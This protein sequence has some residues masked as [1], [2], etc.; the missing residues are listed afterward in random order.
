M[1][2]SF[3]TADSV[4]L[5]LICA[6]LHTSAVRYGSTATRADRGRSSQCL[7]IPATAR[8]VSEVA[9]RAN[10]LKIDF[11]ELAQRGGRNKTSSEP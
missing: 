7:F 3:L 2:G 9:L 4:R 10:W 11:C 1:D 6:S 8:H 5:E